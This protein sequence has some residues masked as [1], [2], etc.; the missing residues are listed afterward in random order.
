MR[1]TR[2]ASVVATLAL[3]ASA[4][5][6][7]ASTSGPAATGVAPT[8]VAPAGDTSLPNTTPPPMPAAGGGSCGVQID[9]GVTMS[10]HTDQTMATL[11]MDSWLSSEQRT[12]LNLVADDAGFLMNCQD[13]S[14]SVSLLTTAGTTVATFAQGPG[15][16][17]IRQQAAGAPASAPGQI[18]ALVNLHDK[19]IWGVSEPG[20]L[21]ITTLGS[22]HFV[23]T[24]EFK[25]ATTGSTPISATVSGSFDLGCTSGT[26]A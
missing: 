9:G 26:C 11:Q 17:V 5:G 19:N 13:A 25:M 4:C 14:G 15:T 6:S 20:T 22:N 2:F 18:S 16:Y 8:G 21:T 3:V 23:G 7:A 12:M 10:W 24:F 1:I